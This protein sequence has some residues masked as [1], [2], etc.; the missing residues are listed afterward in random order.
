M[1]SRI[2]L[3]VLYMIST[4]LSYLLMLVVMTFNGYLFL[5]SVFGLAFGYYIFGFLK[6]MNALK[7]Q[8]SIMLQKRLGGAATASVP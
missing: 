8:K 3:T 4:G 2:I 6:K 5:A 7:E 1:G